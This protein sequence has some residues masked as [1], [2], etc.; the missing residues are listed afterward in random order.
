MTQ[1]AHH[2]I[3]APVGSARQL[4]AQKHSIGWNELHALFCSGST[5]HELRA[6]DYAGRFEAFNVAPGITQLIELAARTWM[7]WRGKQFDPAHSFGSNILT[8]DSFSL[9]RLAAPSYHMFMPHGHATY[10]AFPF[11]TY[12][13]AGRRDPELQVLKID[14]DLPANPRFSVRR[15]Q[16][17]LVQ[18]DDNLYLGK[19]YFKWW[20]GSWQLWAYFSLRLTQIEHTT[21]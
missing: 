2:P 7:P 13:A 19:A 17:E 1:P 14:Y 21:V 6:G 8:S 20:W 4:Q 18:I 5:P 16:D 9:V 3:S 11:R 10:T 12:F 15:L